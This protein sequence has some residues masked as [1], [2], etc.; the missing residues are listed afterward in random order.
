MTVVEFLSSLAK[1]DIRLWLEEGNLRFNAPEGAFTAEVRDE[2]VA[3]K[4]EIIAFLSRVTKYVDTPIALASRDEPLSLSYSQQRLWLLDQLDPGSAAYSMPVILRLEGE[5]DVNVLQQ[6][7]ASI[8]KRHE[9][10]R[11][12][13][14]V[15]DGVAVQVIDPPSANW[16]L[17]VTELKLGLELNDSPGA[18]RQDALRKLIQEE[19]AAPFD[20]LAG[21]VFRTRLIKLSDSS[22]SSSSADE[23]ILLA[24]MHHIVSDGWS[25]GVLVKEV[26]SL[27]AALSA[28]TSILLPP[29][30]LQ[31]ADYAV[32]QRQWLSGEVLERQLDYWR[33]QLEGVAV[34]ALPTDHLRSAVVSDAGAEFTFDLPDELT[35]NLQALAL[36]K[37][38]TLFM[39]LLAAFN[40]LLHRYTAQSD[41]CVG[42]PIANRSR[43]ELDSLIGCFVNTLAFRNDLSGDPTFSELL[44]QV[45]EHARSAYE[46]QDVPFE[47]LVDELGVARDMSHTP[48]FQTFFVLQNQHEFS[49]LELGG[50]KV[51][52]VDLDIRTSKFDLSLAMAESEKS[53]AG[54]FSYRTQL[55]DEESIQRLVANWQC[56]LNAIVSNPNEKIA[57]LNLLSQSEKRRL[58]VD[59]NLTKTQSFVEHEYCLHQLFEK[60][61]EISPNKIALVFGDKR[62]SYEELNA[63][64][65]QLA[66]VLQRFK[67]QPDSLVGLCVERGIEMVVAIYGILKSGAAYVPLDPAYPKDRLRHMLS[68]SGASVLLTQNHLRALMPETNAEI[69]CLDDFSDKIGKENQHNLNIAVQAN[70][71]AYVIYTSGSTGVPKGVAIEHRNTAALVDWAKTV[72][73]QDDLNGVLAG[74]SIC[75]DLSVWEIFVT[76]SCGGK[77]IIAENAL[78]LPDI[79]AAH[80]V[81]LVNTVPSVIASLLRENAIPPQ[82]RVINLAGEALKQTL[83]D[84]LHNKVGIER[85]YDLY[86]PSEDTTYSTFGLRTAGGRANIGRPI[87]NTQTYIL[88]KYLAP[89]PY[90]VPGELFVAGGGVARGYLN[91][92]KLT[93]EKFL[94]NPFK[95]NRMYQTGDLVRYLPDGKLEY[96][97]RIDDQVKVRGFR[98]ELGEVELAVLQHVAIEET[99]VTTREADDEE[100]VDRL[101]VCF[102]VVKSD[103]QLESTGPN[104]L[105]MFLKEKLPDYMIPSEFV[106][107]DEFPLT[108]N[109]KVDRRKLLAT[110]PSLNKLSD[111]SEQAFIAPR[112]EVEIQLA[113]IWKQVLGLDTVGVR[114]N[115]FDLGGHSLIATQVLSRMRLQ[116]KLELP[117]RTIFVNP[118]IE[119]IA[120]AIQ[121]AQ[122]DQSHP[123]SNA[124]PIVAF[125]RDSQTEIPL[126]FA[127]QRLWLIDKIESGSV[128]YNMPAAFRVN[129]ALDPD[130]LQQAMDA[131]IERHEILRTTFRE[132]NDSVTQCVHAVANSSFKKKQPH[133]FSTQNLSHLQGDI[134]EKAINYHVMAEATQGFNLSAGP[135]LR[136][137]ILDLAQDEYVVLATMHHIISDGWSMGVLISEL[138]TLYGAFQ[139]G[140]PSPLNPLPIQYADFSVWQRD[141]LQGDVLDQQLHYWQKN[142]SNA[143][144]TVLP[145]DFPRTNDANYQGDVELFRVGKELTQRLDTL[146]KAEG[147]TLYMTL[148]AAVNVLLSRYSEQQDIVIGTPIANR[149]RVE[150]EPL[151]GFFVNTLA[152]RTDLSEDPSFITIVRRVKESTLGAY[153]HQDVPFERLLDELQLERDL[154]RS[155]LF[156]V[157]F[158]FQNTLDSQSLTLNQSGTLNHSITMPGFDMVP[159]E[160]SSQQVKFDLSINMSLVD[161]EIQGSISYKTGL[162]TQETIAA[163]TGYLVKVLDRVAVTPSL[164]LSSMPVWYRKDSLLTD[165]VLN[166]NLAL[167]VTASS[168]DLSLKDVSYLGPRNEIE[169]VVQR[170]WET[171]LKRENISI[172]SDFFELGGHSLLANRIVSRLRRRFKVKLPL[173]QLFENPT[174]E[175]IASLIE[176]ALAD[177]QH[178]QMASAASKIP[179]A[180]RQQKLP[181]SFA[182]ERM[183][184]LD[185]LDPGGAAYNLPIALRLTGKLEPE[186]LQLAF[187]ELVI[188]HEILRTTFHVEDDEVWQEIH[189]VDEWPLPIVDLSHLSVDAANAELQALATKEATQGF[190]LSTGPLMRTSLIKLPISTQ[191][192]LLATMHH[193]ITDGWSLGLLMQELSALYDAFSK[194]VAPS[195]SPLEIQY[196]DYAFWQRHWLDGQRL[197]GQ[198]LDGRS[199]KESQFKD[200]G[201]DVSL[202]EQIDYWRAQIKPESFVLNLPTDFPRENKQSLAGGSVTLVLP[203][204]LSHR[205][206]QLNQQEG[207][208]LY[209]SLLAVF[210]ILLARYTG[211]Q[212]VNVGS[213]IAGRNREEIEPLI[214]FFINTLVMSVDVSSN[215]SFIELLRRVREVALGAYANQD[216]PFE[217]LVE[218]LNPPRDLSRTPL[219]QVFLNVL[220]LPTIE[221]SMEALKVESLEREEFEAQSKFD[222]TLYVKEVKA[223]KEAEGEI[224]GS[225]DL[226]KDIEESGKSIVLN[227]VYNRALFSADRMALLL[228][229]FQMILNQVVTNPD[230]GV[231]SLSFSNGMSHACAS[232]PV[233]EQA[234]PRV[235]YES[236]LASFER[237][238]LKNGSSIAV[239][240]QWGEWSYQ[241]LDDASTRLANALM[242]GQLKIETGDCVAIYAARQA[243]LVVALLGCFKARIP[244]ALLDPAHPHGKLVTMYRSLGKAVWL[245][246]STR[247]LPEQLEAGLSKQSSN[248][249]L[250]L[251]S[252]YPLMVE[253]LELNTTAPLVSLESQSEDDIAYYS[254]TS[255]TTGEP[256]LIATSVNPLGHFLHWYQET[257]DFTQQDRFSVLSGLGHDPLLRDIFTPLSVGAQLHMPNTDTLLESGCLAQW[258]VDNAITV[259]HLTPSIAHLILDN[260]QPLQ[261]DTLRLVCYGGEELRAHDLEKMR[262]FASQAKMINFYGATETPQAVSYKELSFIENQSPLIGDLITV[263]QGIE[264]VDIL[265]LNSEGRLAAISEVGE[266]CIRTPYLSQGYLNDRALTEQR[267]KIVNWSSTEER[268][269]FTG[270]QGRY[271]INGDVELLG[272]SDSQVKVRGNRIE[273]GEIEAALN[274]VEWIQQAC[275]LVQEADLVVAFLTATD[276]E[277]GALDAT[278]VN[279]LRASLSA[280][281]PEFMIPSVFRLVDRIPLTPSGKMNRGLLPKVNPTQIT[282]VEYVEPT[283]DVEKLVAAMWQ[284]I[285]NVER[286]GLKDNFFHLGGHSLLATK[287]VARIRTQYAIELP[288]RS[289]FEEPTLENLTKFVETTLWV[290]ETEEGKVDD[291]SQVDADREEFEL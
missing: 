112:S 21:P 279:P 147:C 288:L 179:L 134:L 69:V 280:T 85:V 171:V 191:R 267:F 50:L 169:T 3:R 8:V 232:L 34:L 136:I 86:G 32:W 117:L 19:V 290:R 11:T 218:E 193:M 176:D 168:Q 60:Q 239:T 146:S 283:T 122:K 263:G 234:I 268:V 58:V 6:V 61:V 235:E 25:M 262:A 95:D 257:F 7:L 260:E 52:P 230:E 140:E 197:D 284:D 209:M 164:T 72:Y 154:S 39:L 139:R 94:S 207:C 195:F 78:E 249:R 253:Q 145:T 180:D 259:T 244:F 28:G 201:I 243:N 115:F 98:I 220:N 103:C 5:L 228:E 71:L 183:W 148:M 275:V 2:I 264:G 93:A 38:V 100:G 90:G 240:D 214:G 10:L 242:S 126:S 75:F 138:Q 271:C 157:L 132:D 200:E 116:F 22:S 198:R 47:R 29:L 48:L 41:I 15:V 270:D 121:T 109:G 172:T 131:I 55:F 13:F 68:H 174:I 224:K 130:I 190:D 84:A 123:T 16:P 99:L 277:A 208:T 102:I 173:R 151:I 278:L 285:L 105:R 30:P 27:Y 91:E 24:N 222:L 53:L 276:K 9:I 272:R 87:Q 128:A 248:R 261:S 153:A 185:Q 159:M 118:T 111:P 251:A 229:H 152:I 210:N 135:L 104:S 192:A 213:P 114:D 287:I 282:G 150:L 44:E 110:I 80:E 45:K 144:L 186:I 188:R 202:K 217:K 258:F 63:K 245:Q 184:F 273:L 178:F 269:Y 12:R 166:D 51:S 141:W 246:L 187:T 83:V 162:F 167:T 74:T 226:T 106:L 76:L 96:L 199:V 124:G 286:V 62:M 35:Q 252:E 215:P 73:S 65:N 37:E 219:F 46:H 211:Q 36:D 120:I 155:P 56:L 175:G 165:E 221:T 18:Q 149:N 43:Q 255:G 129:G 196:A 205:I 227:L 17:S 33:K 189:P 107:L 88:D 4:P 137:R 67:L 194:G 20:L 170:S 125:P 231:D 238:A 54:K 250:T 82:V 266:V 81:R 142:L 1:K 241:Q 59:L 66:R 49:T 64:S 206:H 158:A 57:K 233:L 265:V 26:S 254:F 92:P 281:L 119:S 133:Y 77:L 256:K 108:P 212:I 177:G 40:V 289:L 225:D 143:P 223:V 291:D 31:Y 14:D 203:K 182:Q 204:S 23:Y 101:L 236:P 237:H 113:L 181:L 79:P 247:A 70:Q 156:Q 42:S 216:L 163:M 161:G 89:V 274:T 127:Q 97:G 160:S